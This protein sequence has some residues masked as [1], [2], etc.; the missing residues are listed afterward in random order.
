MK[1]HRNA[2][3]PLVWFW[4]DEENSGFFCL[5]T[6][7]RRKDLEF[8]LLV[9][10]YVYI[11]TYLYVL[12]LE[13]GRRVGSFFVGV[14][15][16]L[17]ACYFHSAIQAF[18]DRRICIG[19]QWFVCSAAACCLQLLGE[20]MLFNFAVAI[21]FYA[22]YINVEGKHPYR[23]ID[24]HRLASMEVCRGLH[25]RMYEPLRA[26]Q[27]RLLRQSL[28]F[29]FVYIYIYIYASGNNNQRA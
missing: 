26:Q 4:G 16:Q 10:I 7:R 17:L 21:L 3:P 19:Q 2:Q 5:S 18:T 23:T 12:F 25:V 27:A 8:L 24:V 20:A 9:Y 13:I 1:Y 15:R 14:S 28:I 11:C 22:C 29:V 6:H